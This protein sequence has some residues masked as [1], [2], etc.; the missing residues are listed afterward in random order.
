MPLW[1]GAALL[2]VCLCGCAAPQL[3]HVPSGGSIAIVMTPD[4]RVD[5]L[6]MVPARSVTEKADA[7]G[8]VGG[9]MVGAALGLACGPFAPFCVPHAIQLGVLAGS[10]TR[11]L[12]ARIETSPGED[13][14]ALVLAVKRF[15]ASHPPY[16]MALGALREA[17][18]LHWRLVDDD[19]TTP[20]IIV[21]GVQAFVE[22]L[23]GA[24]AQ[25]YV[26]MIVCA[27][28]PGPDAWKAPDRALDF[29]GEPA[30]ARTWAED[31]DEFI[32]TAFAIAYAGVAAR[33][34]DEMTRP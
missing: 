17:V 26:K 6:A 31:R 25:A 4:A 30:P 9:A 29:T 5:R 34:V 24:R 20:R 8:T 3:A 28:V 19:R 2:S 32:V 27:E 7:A 12:A 33:I 14:D 22:L 15:E 23:P 18:A 10:G 16:D 21:K 11:V 1:L 13:H